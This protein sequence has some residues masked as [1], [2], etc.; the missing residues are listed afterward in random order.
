MSAGTAAAANAAAYG[1]AAAGR[2]CPEP[3]VALKGVSSDGQV[4]D[5][6]LAF[7]L[8]AQQHR[9]KE[10][11]QAYHRGDENRTRQGDVVGGRV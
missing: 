1:A 2:G 11:C 6:Y 4:G 5:E 8:R 3:V 7:R 10:D 9:D